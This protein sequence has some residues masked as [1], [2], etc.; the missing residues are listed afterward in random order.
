MTTSTMREPARAIRLMVGIGCWIAVLVLYAVAVRT[1]PGR[2]VDDMAFQQLRDNLSTRSW[3]PDGTSLARS[4]LAL[5]VIGAGVVCATCSV[6]R[7]APRTTTAALAL[8]CAPGLL[9]DVLKSVLTRPSSPAE[10]VAHNSFPSGTVAAF[11]GV[12]SALTFV[13]RSRLQQ[14]IACAA[15]SGT[16]LIALIVIRAHWHRPSDVLGALLLALGA[17]EVA[18]GMTRGARPVRVRPPAAATTA[19][20]ENSGPVCQR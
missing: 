2:L 4:Q 1:A 13:A 7:C 16:G 18:S 10:F 6:N 9:A 19:D 14:G 3:I 5:L 17:L 11:A 12:A 20:L 15:W 8:G